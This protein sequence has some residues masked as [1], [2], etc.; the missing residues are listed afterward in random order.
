MK[1]KYFNV[2]QENERQKLN[3]QKSIQENIDLE[4]SVRRLNEEKQKHVDEVYSVRMGINKKHGQVKQREEQIDQ[5]QA[6]HNELIKK[7]AHLIIKEKE[8][9][10]LQT[11]LERNLD[12]IGQVDKHLKTLV[13]N[14]K[15]VV[16]QSMDPVIIEHT[17][18]QIKNIE[19]VHKDIKTTMSKK[20]DSFFED[21][22]TTAKFGNISRIS[23]AV[24]GR[25]SLEA[26][27][28]ESPQTGGNDI[29]KQS[30][31]SSSKTAHKQKKMENIIVLKEAKPSSE[32]VFGSNTKSNHSKQT[33]AT[34]AK[35][36]RKRTIKQRQKAS[37]EVKDSYEKE[38]YVPDQKRTRSSTT[39]F[40]A[41]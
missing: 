16:D 29:K 13:R 7:A 1:L 25:Q 26:A 15:N 18:R 34:E 11:N 37:K 21:A 3:V 4:A 24:S 23:E 38:N 31:R 36:T 41:R 8:V 27:Y 9:S 10:I 32:A 14:L 28:N 39:P 17:Q 35:S 30:P 19:K 5:L 6:E 22:A 40:E 33:M 12:I 2:L 20:D